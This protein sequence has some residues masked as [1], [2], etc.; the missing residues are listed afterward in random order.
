MRGATWLLL[1]VAILFGGC[2]SF[3]GKMPVLIFLSGAILLVLLQ[4]I[5]LPPALWQRLPGHALL[6]QAAT[7]SGQA[8]PS[9]PW[10]IVP[11]ATVNALSSLVVPAAMLLFIAGLKEEERQ[12]LPGLILGLIGASTLVGL[13][14]FSGAG[15]DNPL[16]NDTSDEVSGTFANRNHLA[17]FLAFGLLI[18][19]VWAFMGGRRPSWRAPVT[20]GLVLLFA[21]TILASGSRAG[22]L[23]GTIALGIGLG[24]TQKVIRKALDCYPRWVFWALILAIIGMIILFV[25][26]SIAAGRAVSISR[27][28]VLDPGQDMRSRSL[29][30]IFAMIRA[31][32]PMGYGFGGFDSVFRIHEPLSLLE[33]DYFNHAHDDFL[34]ILLEAGLPGAILLVSALIWWLAASVRAWSGQRHALPRLGSAMLLLLFIASVFDYPARTPM[35]MGMIVVASLW[36][37]DAAKKQT[38][39]A[40]PAKD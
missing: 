14:Q 21:L 11:S 40:L 31:Y 2:P 19:P 29:P 22:L 30:T 10:A 12:W 23:V 18:A 3:K 28:L 4:L 6:A 38:R 33:Y 27:V 37:C 25:L 36:L 7:V 16:I 24:L 17:L 13:L 39:S 15:F 26:V 35:M 32:F 9:R 20:V 5:P 8:Q 1:L 34:E